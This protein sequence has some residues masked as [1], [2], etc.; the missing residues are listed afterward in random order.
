MQRMRLH[1]QGIKLPPLGSVQDKVLRDFAMREAGL[2]AKRAEFQMLT[3]LTNP[4]ISDEAK[5]KEWRGTVKNIWQQYVGLLYN[6]DTPETG[7]KDKQLIDYYN[8]V[9]KPSKLQMYK[10]SKTGSL[11]LIGADSLL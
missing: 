10:D 4:S 8:L 3:L 2:E 1:V 6:V 11:K 5:W 9:V 7:N